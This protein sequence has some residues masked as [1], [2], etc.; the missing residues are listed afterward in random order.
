MVDDLSLQS[1]SDRGEQLGLDDPRGQLYTEL[2]RILAVKQPKAFLFENVASLVTMSGGKRNRVGESEQVGLQRGRTFSTILS[3][4]EACGYYLS[5]HIIDARHF[6][7]QHRE[8]VYI[9]GYRR[10][11]GVFE[12]LPWP[13]EEAS[14]LSAAGGGFTSE[15]CLRLSASAQTVA[16]ILETSPAADLSLTPAQWSR[17]QSQHGGEAGSGRWRRLPKGGRSREIPVHGKAPTLTS[18]YH[19]PA[20]VSTRFICHHAD[21]SPLLLPRFLSPRECCRL[22]GFP[23]NFKVCPSFL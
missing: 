6:L 2:V 12:G 18:S 14:L 1:F 11:L 21:G 19:T 7:P 9:V 5:H 15:D 16:D 23:E 17:I 8:R 4:L 10:D 3:A 22:M 20:S 13:A